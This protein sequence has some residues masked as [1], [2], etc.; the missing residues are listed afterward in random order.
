MSTRSTARTTTIRGLHPSPVQVE[1]LEALG[2]EPLVFDRRRD[3]RTSGLD[4]LRWRRVS[5][6]GVGWV[7]LDRGPNPGDFTRIEVRSALFN[8]ERRYLACFIH[9][10]EPIGTDGLARPAP[11]GKEG[12]HGS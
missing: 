1:R 2:P 3:L 10:G 9:P 4:E 11:H 12:H 6:A 7:K 8:G 5:L